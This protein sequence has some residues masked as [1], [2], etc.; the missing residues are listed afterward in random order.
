MKKSKAH[1]L[2]A[3]GLALIALLASTAMN[4]RAPKRNNATFAINQPADAA[5]FNMI[6]SAGAAT[7]KALAEPDTFTTIDFPGATS[8]IACGI[9]PRGD[10]VGD[11]VS[12]GRGHGFLLSRRE[13][14]EDNDDDGPRSEH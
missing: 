14:D 2:V 13:R 5:T 3:A 6:V 9:N 12:A 11:Y 8:T 1:L 4:G 7:S 10:I